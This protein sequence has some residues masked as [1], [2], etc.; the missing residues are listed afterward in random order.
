MEAGL[1]GRVKWLIAIE[2]ERADA[3]GRMEMA[4]ALTLLLGLVSLMAGCCTAS[5]EGAAGG[6]V[7]MRDG[8]K[9][10]PEGALVVYTQRQ[11]FSTLDADHEHH[12]PYAIYSE[13]GELVERV[14]NQS[15]SFGQEV[16]TVALAP[17]RYQ[18]KTWT[19]E[20]GRVTV[21]VEIAA[22]KTT[23]L[24]VDGER[25]VAAH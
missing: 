16:S 21:P 15:G 9:S 4:L 8:N 12:A 1:N 22:D 5:K 25:R 19:R 7:A 2:K 17:G 23:I 6:R 20:F 14:R 13:A 3:P 11:L 10:K 24:H 18:I